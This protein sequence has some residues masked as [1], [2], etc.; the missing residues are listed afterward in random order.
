MYSPDGR[1]MAYVSD[2]IWVKN[3]PQDEAKGIDRELKTAIDEAMK[4]LRET[5]AKVADR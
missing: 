2:E 1:K 4:M 5:R 3:S